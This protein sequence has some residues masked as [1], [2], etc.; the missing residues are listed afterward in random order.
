MSNTGIASIPG[1]TEDEREF[2]HKHNVPAS[3]LFDAKYFRRREYIEV[4]KER[5]LLFV[6]NASPCK[7]GGHRLRT[8]PGH[9]IVCNPARIA[10]IKRHVT[11]G[12]VY[13]AYS[14]SAMLV[15]VGMTEKRVAERL[16]QLNLHLYGGTSDWRSE[17]ER[18]CRKAGAVEFNVHE[19]LSRKSA[20][21]I[22][23]ERS[24][25]VSECRELF[26]C[27]SSA[28]ISAVKAAI[29]VVESEP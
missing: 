27:S 5:D 24:G 22:Y 6:Y 1:L 21:G 17:F 26:R 13:V 9:C 16:E 28:A 3:L 25:I 4:M 18:H 10:F 14:P 8:R 7:A 19:R 23:Y 11:P 29:R 15:K 12:I 2:L 20:P